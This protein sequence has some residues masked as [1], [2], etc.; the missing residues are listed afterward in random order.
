MAIVLLIVILLLLLGPQLWTHYV[1][2]KYSVD[3]A[4]FPGTGA[5]L[6]RH[7]LDKFSLQ[8]VKVEQIDNG[9]HYD[10][11]D[12]CVRLEPRHYQRRSLAAVAVA[13]HEVGHAIQHAS[14][15]RPLK[16]RS[17]LVTI[18]AWAEKAAVVML[19]LVPVIALLTRSPI[20]GAASIFTALGLFLLPILVHLVTLPVELDASFARA[21]PVLRGMQQFTDTELK[22][23]RQILRACALTYVAGSLSSVLNFW[24]WIAI[25]RR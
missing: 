7:I 4:H 25:L 22:Q 2:H 10:P 3:V 8:Q 1:L 24:R 21:L 12:R 9:D 5:Q 18:A 6:A 11:S 19:M 23:I 13:A 16:L 15:Y 20:G 17:Q 14:E